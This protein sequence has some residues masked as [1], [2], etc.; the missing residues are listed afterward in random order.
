M[1]PSRSFRRMGPKNGGPTF[2]VLTHTE[3]SPMGKSQSSSGKQTH[4]RHRYHE[5]RRNSP[6]AAERERSQGDGELTSE[7]IS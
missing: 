2:L 3:A 4:D 6:S 1:T 5:F 7:R